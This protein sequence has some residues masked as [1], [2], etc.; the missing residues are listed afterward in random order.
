MPLPIHDC[1]VMPVSRKP[2]H[3]ENYVSISFHI[4]WD[5]IVV[6]VFLWILNQMDFHLVQNRKETCHHDH[7][8][9]NLKGNENIVFSVKPMEVIKPRYQIIM[10]ILYI[11]LCKVFLIIHVNNIGHNSLFIFYVCIFHIVLGCWFNKYYS[12]YSLKNCTTSIARLFLSLFS[13]SIMNAFPLIQVMKERTEM[14]QLSKP[15]RFI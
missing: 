10:Q 2:V 15:D 4:E 12:Y 13:Q 6:T 1:H 9:L 8:P 3:W 5:V 11:W 7:I 14:T